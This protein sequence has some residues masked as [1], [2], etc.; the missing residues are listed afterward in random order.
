MQFIRL[1]CWYYKW[2]RVLKYTTDMTLGGMIYV[3]HTK[4]HD[5]GIRH[6]N[7]IK[8]IT[9]TMRETAVLVLLMVSGGM[10]Y[11]TYQVS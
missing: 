7:Y 6:S 2:A 9:S 1:Q 5:S 4:F 10:I 11:D 8:N 3:V